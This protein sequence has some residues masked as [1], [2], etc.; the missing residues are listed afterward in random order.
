MVESILKDQK[1]LLPCSVL[2]EGEYNAK[3]VFIGVP[4]RLGKNGVEEIVE[5]DLSPQEK[6]DFSKSIK[7]IQKIFKP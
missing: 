7:H 2:L 4:V 1:K 5:L 6:S 3:G